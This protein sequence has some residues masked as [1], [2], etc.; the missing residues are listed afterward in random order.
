[1]PKSPDSPGQHEG[2]RCC[3]SRQESPDWTW[4][5]ATVQFRVTPGGGVKNGTQMQS[6]KRKL[7]L[8]HERH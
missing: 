3:P 1:M 7:D 5:M 4:R 8:K 6:Q 2:P